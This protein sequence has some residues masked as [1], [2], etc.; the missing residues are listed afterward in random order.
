MHKWLANQIAALHITQQVRALLMCA[1]V[2]MLSD[3]CN[4][5]LSV[6]HILTVFSRLTKKGQRKN[7][8]VMNNWWRFH[9]CYSLIKT[10]GYSIHVGLYGELIRTA[11]KVGQLNT[12]LIPMQR[13]MYSLQSTSRPNCD[14]SAV[15]FKYCWNFPQI[16][17]FQILLLFPN[18][19]TRS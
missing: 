17:F 19:T 8:R 9:H 7:L 15:L 5:L 18:R 11:N 12:Q 14:F 6:R 4:W 1:A 3:R 16:N 13:K 2:N 10:L